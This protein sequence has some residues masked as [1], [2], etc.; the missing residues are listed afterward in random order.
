MAVKYT[1][2]KIDQ[3][4]NLYNRGEGL[5]TEEIARQL[6]LSTRSVVAKLSSLGVY[7]PKRYLNKRGEPPRSKETLIEDLAR[8][9]DVEIF[10]LDS[11]E[12]VNKAVI[13]LLIQKYT[14]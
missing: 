2:E 8:V 1:Q 12:K 6:D 9:L 4:L 10:R 3:L 14:K 13:L 5:S 11:L 7:I